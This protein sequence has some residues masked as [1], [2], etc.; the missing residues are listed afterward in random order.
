MIYPS[1]DSLRT[2]GFD[3]KPQGWTTND[4]YEYM[5]PLQ[6]DPTVVVFGEGRGKTEWRLTCFHTPTGADRYATGAESRRQVRI[7]IIQPVVLH[8]TY[9]NLIAHVREQQIL[10]CI[11]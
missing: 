2:Q 9:N 10:T 1:S 3:L 11:W 6:V 4:I 5:L 8:Y 7:R